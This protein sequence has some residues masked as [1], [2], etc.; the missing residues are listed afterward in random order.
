MVWD[1]CEVSPLAQTAGSYAGALKW[2]E[3]VVCHFMGLDSVGATALAIKRSA[4]CINEN[5]AEYDL[6]ITDPPYCDAIPYSDLMDFFYV[7]LRRTVF[8]LSPEIDAA[9]SS[10][11]G[12]KWDDSVEMAS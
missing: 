12:P 2:V 7:W 1:Y 6:I 4:I 5:G 11:L 9:M 10:V 8:G 3:L